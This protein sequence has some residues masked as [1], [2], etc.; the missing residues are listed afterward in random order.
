M[1]KKNKVI[2]AKT[3]KEQ[4][5]E[6][7]KQAEV[8]KVCRYIKD[9]QDVFKAD[10]PTL[11]AISREYGERFTRAYVS[12]W[13]INITEFVNIANGMDETQIVETAEMI[14]FDYPYLTLADINLVFG[15]AKRGFY[16]QIYNRLDG[17]IIMT[18]FREYHDE[19]CR[20]AQDIA[21]SQA[22]GFTDVAE[23]QAKIQQTKDVGNTIY[24]KARF[25]K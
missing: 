17:Q 20:V 19:R 16:G 12:A 9:P 15:R 6:I 14:M 3:S 11:G 5:L 23:R 18:W 13:I 1:E 4:F 22:S 25:R 24:K 10:L 8:S 21:I 2:L 7:F